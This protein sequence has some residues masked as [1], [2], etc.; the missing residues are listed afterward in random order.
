MTICSS[1]YKD[2]SVAYSS[3]GFW[4]VGQQQKLNLQINLPYNFLIQ[5]YFFHDNPT[6]NILR[7][8]THISDWSR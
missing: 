5:K 8:P 7:V 1:L 6:W 2:V 3:E 4:L